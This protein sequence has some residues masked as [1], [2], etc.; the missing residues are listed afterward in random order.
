MVEGWSNDGT[1]RVRHIICPED[2][3]PQHRG[4]GD[5]EVNGGFDNG[6]HFTLTNAGD[7]GGNTETL[8]FHFNRWLYILGGQGV[9]KNA[10]VESG[11][12]Q[13]GDYV[14]YTPKAPATEGTAVDEGTGDYAKIAVGGG[15]SLWVPAGAPGAGSA[16][17]DLDLEETLNANVAF[18]KV[19]PVSAPNDD[20]FFDYDPV[21]EEVTLNPTKTGGYNLFDSELVLRKYLNHFNLHGNHVFNLV[22]PAIDPGRV[23]P[24]W[25]HELSLHVT[26]ERD[27]EVEISMNLFVGMPL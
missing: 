27:P 26:G 6:P 7:T 23:L 21:T 25:E 18:T 16:D 5:D 2:A 10:K 8:T 13:G 11:V 17:W 1:R 3:F 20:G 19:V 9:C 15:V 24:H 14:L 4:S 12:G 22:V